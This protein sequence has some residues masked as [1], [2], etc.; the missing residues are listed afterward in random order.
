MVVSTFTGA[1][2]ISYLFTKA[3]FIDNFPRLL[4]LFFTDQD[5]Y[6]FTSSFPEEI[7]PRKR[8]GLLPVYLPPFIIA[9]IF[10]I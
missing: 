10:T 5:Q 6:K 2:F 8:T 9:L 4:K 3:V 7:F 1:F